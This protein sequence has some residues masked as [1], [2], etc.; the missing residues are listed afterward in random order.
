M[1]T[2]RRS[3]IFVDREVQGAL[4]MRVA[5]Y[6]SF[7]L[8]SIMLMVLC[9]SVY[10]GPPR[11]FAEL[12][13]ELFHRYAPAMAA[14]LILL[15][16]AMIDVVRMSNRFVGPIVRL[17]GALNEWAQTGRP[18]PVK[19]R[20]NDYWQDLAADFN[21]VAQTNPIDPAPVAQSPET[22]VVD[23]VLVSEL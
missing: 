22:G 10:T 2:C 15:P 1:S 19:F 9:W 21:R 4:M 8:L 23:D 17:R 18:R 14:S 7:C 5:T 16:I 3:R 13:V 20:D 11:R 6:W 12:F